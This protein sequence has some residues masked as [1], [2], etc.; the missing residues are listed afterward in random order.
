VEGEGGKGEGINFHM[1]KGF[2]FSF[3]IFHFS[4]QGTSFTVTATGGQ[5]SFTITLSKPS[6]LTYPLFSPLP[7]FLFNLSIILLLFHLYHI[8]FIDEW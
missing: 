7:I 1:T 6:V 8:V 4:D 3:F 5:A 2:Y